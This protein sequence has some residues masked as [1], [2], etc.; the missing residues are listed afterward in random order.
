MS[1]RRSVAVIRLA[2]FSA[3]LASPSLLRF[4]Q[5]TTRSQN[6]PRPVAQASLR[7]GEVMIDGRLDDA[8]WAKATPITE[9][10]Q[11]SPDEGK[12]PTQ[13]T[14]L[15]ILYDAGAIYIGARMYDSLGAAGYPLSPGPSRSGDERRQ[16]HH[17][18]Q[19]RRRLR[20]L[21]RQEQPQL[22]RAQSGRSQGRPPG[23]RPVLRSR[24]GG[25]KQDRF[26]RL[27]GGIPHPVLAAPLF[28]CS[29]PDLGHADLAQDR[30]PQRE[31]HVGLLA[32]QR[33]RWPGVF[34]YAR[35]D[36]R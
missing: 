2:C 14:E 34:R 25:R 18:G 28:S 29:G 3:F 30:P 23:R 1:P 15:R 36:S 24:L 32:E 4:A 22:V 19:Y 33:V 20:H 27:D 12:P 7:E 5:V 16:Q 21:P 26:A 6:D 10:V 8:A 9:F 11:S 13:R 31:H 17:V 35:G